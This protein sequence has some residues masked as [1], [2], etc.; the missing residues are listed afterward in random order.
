MHLLPSFLPPPPPE[1]QD[2]NKAATAGTEGRRTVQDPPAVPEGVTC[3]VF[4]AWICRSSPPAPPDPHHPHKCRESRW[5]QRR[6]GGCGSPS[7]PPPGLGPVSLR[8]VAWRGPRAPCLAVPH[9]CGWA[10]PRRIYL[11]VLTVKSQPEMR[12]DAWNRADQSISTAGQPDQK[13]PRWHHPVASGGS[14]PRRDPA[15]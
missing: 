3:L 9:S 10:P 1:K 11:S 6:A 13:P 7:T 12:K 5:G 8:L 15:A 14:G 2:G 4:C